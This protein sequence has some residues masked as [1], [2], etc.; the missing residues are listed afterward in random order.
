[1][2]E[3]VKDI[4]LRSE[5]GQS[6]RITYLYA[7]GSI[8]V[9]ILLIAS[10]NFINMSTARATKRAAEIGVRKV[11]GAFRSSLIRQILSEAMVIVFIS[12]ALS[13]LIVM[14]MLPFFNQVTGKDI[15]LQTE[16]AGY[17]V[18]ALSLLALITGLLAG[19]YPA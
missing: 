10:I 5:I 4:Y 3:P 11:M 16:N 15:S 8:A 9:F 14:L 2:L 12:I 18:I 17:F 6:P 13:A 1:A 19:A 7:I